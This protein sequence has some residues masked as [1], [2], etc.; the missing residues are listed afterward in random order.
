MNYMEKIHAWLEPLVTEFLETGE[1]DVFEKAI[2]DKILE[3]YRNG[4][5]AERAKSKKSVATSKQD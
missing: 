2:K 1:S 5:R 4:Q 3:S